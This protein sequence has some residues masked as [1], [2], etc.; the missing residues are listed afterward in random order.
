MSRIGGVLP[1][2]DFILGERRNYFSNS[3]LFFGFRFLLELIFTQ[4]TFSGAVANTPPQV[5]H[6]LTCYH[7]YEVN[8]GEEA[9]EYKYLCTFHCEGKGWRYG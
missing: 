4:K 9:D 2:H 6:E 8:K 5:N 1:L 3:R 7:K